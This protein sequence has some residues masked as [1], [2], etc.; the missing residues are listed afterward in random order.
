MR[1]YLRRDPEEIC[2]LLSA[3]KPFAEIAA[4]TGS[5]CK[6]LRVFCRRLGIHLF[7]RGDAR[8]FSPQVALKRRLAARKSTEALLTEVV[9]AASPICD[10]PTC[11]VTRELQSARAAGLPDER[12]AGALAALHKPTCDCLICTNLRELQDRF[13]H[14]EIP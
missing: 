2:R 14:R 7:A 4:L 9:A 12:L 8:S 3:G 10:C 1:T 11:A 6:A 5:T 13:S